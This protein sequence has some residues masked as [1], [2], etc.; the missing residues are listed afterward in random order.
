MN[1]K[2]GFTLVELLVVIAIIG[3]LVGLLLPAVQSSREAARRM[4]CT[5][6]LKQIALAAH[7]YHDTFGSFQPGSIK[8]GEVNIIPKYEPN[9]I[10]WAAFVLPFLE[11]Q[12]VYE[13]INFNA[14]AWHWDPNDQGIT[15]TLPTAADWGTLFD[16]NKEAS[17]LAP[18]FFH[19]PS[20]AD[21]G[22]N[23]NGT[24]DY[25]GAGN[26]G[27]WEVP[28]GTRPNASGGIATQ[29]PARDAGDGIFYKA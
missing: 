13:K 3:V 1:I 28:Y 26:G 24:K 15:D 6:H 12:A 9:L 7:N 22:W 14:P 16:A 10:G 4:Q 2:K 17:V 19:C 20:A 8:P 23:R 27:N 18:S 11:A 25:S 21:G 29:F 5:N